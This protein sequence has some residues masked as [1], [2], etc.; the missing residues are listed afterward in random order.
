MGSDEYFVR[1]VLLLEPRG[2]FCFVRVLSFKKI[3][4]Q[5][6]NK[7]VFVSRHHC[8]FLESSD[9]ISRKICFSSGTNNEYVFSIRLVSSGSREL[10]LNTVL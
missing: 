5:T 1:N 7:L 2:H 10:V 8:S 4:Q 6:L 3:R 9:L